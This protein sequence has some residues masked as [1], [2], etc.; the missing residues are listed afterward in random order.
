MFSTDSYRRWHCVLVLG[1][2]LSCG[3][4]VGLWPPL[5][6]KMFVAKS[7][8]GAARPS[9]GTVVIGL[10]QEPPTLDPHASPSAVTFQIMAS[11]SESLLY[12]TP[13]RKLQP[14][15]AESWEVSADGTVFT[16]R[17][18]KDVQFQDGQPLTAEVVKSN[19]DR[20]VDP[21]FKAGAALNALAGYS[22]SE[23]VDEHTVTVQFKKP[24]APFLTAVAGGSLSLVSPKAVKERGDSFGRRPVGTGVF[25]V[26]EYVSK[27]HV[28]LVRNPDYHR[29]PPWGEHAGPAYVEKIVWKFIP[30]PGTRVMTVETAETQMIS[31]VPAQDLPRLEKTRNIRIGEC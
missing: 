26:A 28:T 8:E 9:G 13:E 23:V 4:L 16:F 10:D 12:L 14:W 22:G 5:A 2:L 6:L 20:I 29:T 1:L 25:A 30:E 19:F 18:R 27:D 17:L 11:V 3:V 21:N 31:L 24:Y 7:A 15:L